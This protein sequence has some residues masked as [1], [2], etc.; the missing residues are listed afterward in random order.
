MIACV[1]EP[2]SWPRLERHA[3]GAH[4]ASIAAHVARCPACKQCLDEIERDVVALRPLA[5]P[6]AKRRPW[7]WLALPALAAAAAV[8]VLV[9][10]PERPE[11]IIDVKGVGEVILGVVRERQGAISF[12]AR[13][14]VATDRWKVILTCPPRASAWIEVSV[15]DGITVDHPLAPA[16]LVCG[17]EIAVPGAF[18]ITGAKQNRVCATIAATQGAPPGVACVV[19]S[20]E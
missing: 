18:T 19:L 3:S 14:Y 5:V 11:N 10:R 15:A 4:D 12:D 7:I 8:L 17:N 20:P 13:S 9:L 6:A 1:G 2:I 16:Q